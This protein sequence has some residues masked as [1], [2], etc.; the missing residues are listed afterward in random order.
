MNLYTEQTS[1]LLMYREMFLEVHYSEVMNYYHKL[2]KIVAKKDWPE[3]C[4]PLPMIW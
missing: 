1:M 3:Y 2:K 4:V